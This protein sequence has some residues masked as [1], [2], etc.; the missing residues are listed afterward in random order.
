MS[1]LTSN[2]INDFFPFPVSKLSVNNVWLFKRFRIKTF[3]SHCVKSVQ[4]QSFFWSIFSRIRTTYGENSVKNLRT[5]KKPAFGHFSRSVSFNA[6]LISDQGEIYSQWSDWS[7]CD[8]DN[9]CQKMRQRFCS[10]YNN[11][12]CPEANVYGVHNEYARCSAR[13]CYRK[14]VTEWM[15]GQI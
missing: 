6:F 1:K 8:P 10:Q 3:L 12:K 9:N 7:P 13:E 11:I 4:I 14:F 2:N 5:R 15:K